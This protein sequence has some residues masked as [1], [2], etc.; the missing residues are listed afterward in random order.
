VVVAR[1]FSFMFHCD[2]DKWVTGGAKHVNCGVE[3]SVR[4]VTRYVRN[5]KLMY[6]ASVV[7]VCFFWLSI[8]L[9]ST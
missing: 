7:S 6:F 2:D 1:K 9:L 4:K 5:I 8:N 3:Q